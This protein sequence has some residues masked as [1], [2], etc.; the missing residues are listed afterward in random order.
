MK[1]AAISVLLGAA[2]VIPGC[3]STHRVEPVRTV[4]MENPAPPQVV[5]V[6]EQPSSVIVQ[7]A[8]RP[9]A[10]IDARPIHG[11]HYRFDDNEMIYDE[12]LRAYVVVGYDNQ[13]YSDGRYYRYERN[14]WQH[15]M[16]MRR[17]ARWES[18]HERNVPGSLVVRYRR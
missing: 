6:R 8:P 9:A 12:S 18:I 4:R 3:V 7:Q 15:S 17:D 1:R 16:H 2:V 11:Q 13:Y 5:I 14:R 10:T